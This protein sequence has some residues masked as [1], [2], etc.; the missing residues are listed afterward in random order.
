MTKRSYEPSPM[1]TWPGWVLS[2]RRIDGASSR[3]GLSTAAAASPPSS[4]R[5]RPCTSSTAPMAS[6]TWTCGRSYSLIPGS[7]W[8]ADR[9]NVSADFGPSSLGRQK[10]N[11]L[12]APNERARRAMEKVAQ[13]EGRRVGLL[14]RALPVG[15]RAEPGEAIQDWLAKG[16]RHGHGSAWFLSQKA[17]VLIDP[18][19]RRGEVLWPIE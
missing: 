12:A 19:P 13:Y 4:L 10:Y 3:P 9:R 1:S 15:P 8:P 17:V 16:Q 7:R 14:M 6:R 2:P 18:G 11:L 5:A